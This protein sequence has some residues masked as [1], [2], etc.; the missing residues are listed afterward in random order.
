MVALVRDGTEKQKEYAARLKLVRASRC[1]LTG[2]EMRAVHGR[3]DEGVY[4]LSWS[5]FSSL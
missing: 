2:I 1:D 3:R 4:E 5:L